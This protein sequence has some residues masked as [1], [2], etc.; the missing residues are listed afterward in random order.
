MIKHIKQ[1]INKTN[2][3]RPSLIR[4]FEFYQRM[5]KKLGLDIKTD[6]II[7]IYEFLFVVTRDS[8][9]EIE[10]L[11]YWGKLALYAELHGHHKHPAYA[12]GLAAA[13]AGLPIRHDVMNGI[14]FFDDRVEKVRISKGQSDSNAKQMY[15]EAQKALENPQGSIS[16]KAMNKVV[17]YMEY[18]YH[19]TRLKVTTLIED[20]DFYY[21]S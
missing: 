6:P 1:R 21:R 15:F 18:G 13:K 14:D 17:K 12:I 11:K 9:K 3:P 5:A 8:G 4:Q 10:F 2:P 7:W 19:S 16:K 20:F